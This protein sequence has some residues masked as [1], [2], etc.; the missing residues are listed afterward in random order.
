MS[1]ITIVVDM[2]TQYGKYTSTENGGEFIRD[3]QYI[4]DRIV[5]SVSTPTP[6][7]DGRTLW[8]AEPRRYRL[9]AARACPWAHRT[10]ITR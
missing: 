10:V 4:D 1:T 5:D 6:L 2:S 8:P 7:E 3:T 9:V